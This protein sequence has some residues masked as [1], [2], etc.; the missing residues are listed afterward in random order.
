[1]IRTQ[2]E[3]KPKLRMIDKYNFQEYIKAKLAESILGDK[4]E[5]NLLKQ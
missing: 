3:Y 4:E 2:S 1:M 5:L